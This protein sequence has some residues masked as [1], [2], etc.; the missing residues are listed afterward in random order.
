MKSSNR[1]VLVIG[2]T[3]NQGGTVAR[4]LL[5]KGWKVRAM[6]RDSSKPAAQELKELGA[7]LVQGSIQERSS[8][9]KAMEGAYGVFSVQQF[10]EHGFDAEVAQGKIVADA[11]RSAGVEHFVYS[12]VGGAERE[13]GIAHFD[14]KRLIERHISSLGLPATILR[15]VFFMDNFRFFAPPKANNGVMEFS[16]PMPPHQRLQMIAAD[17]IGEF[18]A[19]AFEHPEQW[20]GKEME[21]AGDEPTMTEIAATY[22]RVTGAPAR[23]VQQPM[24]QVRAFSEDAAVMYEW[25]MKGGYKAD[26]PS[27]RKMYPGLM[28]WE[29]WLRKVGLG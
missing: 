20:M 29:M 15:P 26:I 27:L 6:N 4:H 23:F 18:V 2:A 25:F 22:E 11:A 24:E 3:G 14:S 10:W 9:D 8:V 13:T 12:S 17:D 5:K 1:T 19:M 28:T 16:L 21:L 7:E